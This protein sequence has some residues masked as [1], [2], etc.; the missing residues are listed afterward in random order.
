MTLLYF[1]PKEILL[2]ILIKKKDMTPQGYK[3]AHN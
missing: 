1:A 3:Q 2:L